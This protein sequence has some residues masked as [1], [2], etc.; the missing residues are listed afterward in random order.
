MAGDDGDDTY[1]SSVTIHLYGF[2]DFAEDLAIAMGAEGASSA[3]TD[4]MNEAGNSSMFKGNDGGSLKDPG[5]EIRIQALKIAAVINNYLSSNSVT[6]L[7]TDED[8]VVVCQSPREGF[9]TDADL[10]D[11]LG[12][13]DTVLVDPF[14]TGGGGAGD[15]D[16]D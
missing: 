16:I 8:P 11:K 5:A 7:A 9:I 15:S 13:I 6:V 3:I 12:D 4:A 14:S 1:S 10:E 2:E